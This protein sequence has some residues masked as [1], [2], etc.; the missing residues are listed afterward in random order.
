MSE[1]GSLP[2]AGCCTVT[3]PIKTVLHL[4]GVQ[5]V[6]LRS[7]NSRHSS[8]EAQ[9]HNVLETVCAIEYMVQSTKHQI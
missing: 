2:Y 5:Y 8:G 9:H 4:Q 3:V 1:R 7:G 6:A